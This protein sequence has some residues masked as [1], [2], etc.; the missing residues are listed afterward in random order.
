[1]MPVMAPVMLIGVLVGNP[2]GVIAMFLSFFPLTA[3][4]GLLIR[5]AFSTVPTWQII[6]STAILVVSAAGALWLAGRVFRFGMLRYGKRMGWK[7][8][9]QSIRPDRTPAAP[10]KELA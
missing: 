1:M 9:F 3:S 10:D 8:V 2:S 5:M 6:V 4:L 7:D